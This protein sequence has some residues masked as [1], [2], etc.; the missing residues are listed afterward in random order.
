MFNVPLGL[1]K[2]AN[3]KYKNCFK[4]DLSIPVYL[5]NDRD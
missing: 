1:H 5:D 4:K 2:V 3:L